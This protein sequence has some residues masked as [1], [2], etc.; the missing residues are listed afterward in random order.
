MTPD[1]Q[2]RGM[3][4][5]TANPEETSVEI[6]GILDTV[7][8]PIVVVG[9][10]CTIARFNLA[11]AELLSLQ[12]L[13]VRRPVFDVLPGFRNLGSL[14]GQAIAD[15]TPHQFQTRW[16]ARYFLVRIAP[17]SIGGAQILGA[18]LTFTN[19]TAFRAS[20]DQAIYER[21]YAKAILNTISE[22][23]VVLDGELRIQTGNRAFYTMFRVSREES[24]RVPLYELGNDWKASGLWESLKR[25]L[26]ENTGFQPVEVER[27]FAVIG[28]RT[29][30]IDARR[31]SL[32][33][34]EMLLLALHDITE[35]KNARQEIVKSEQ[36]LRNL[37]ESI[38]QLVWT[39]V[40]NGNYD[41]LS[42]QWVTYTGIPEAEQLGLRWL[43]LV[44]PEDRQRT[45]GAWMA[46]IEDRVPYDIEHRLKRFD[47][48]HRCFR[49]RGTPVRNSEGAI[50]K[51]FGTCTD[52]EDQK[53]AE[54][55]MLEQQ[56]RE[57]L[58]LLAG[59]IA[60]DFNNLLTGVLGNASL[61]DD[62]LEKTHPFRPLVQGIV[63]A[64]ERA[65]H[66]TR[67]MLAYAGKGR[68]FVERVDVNAL[69]R[70]TGSLVEASFPKSV[71]L[72]LDTVNQA[73]A[74]EADSG[75]IQQVIMNLA[76]NGAEAV[77]EEQTGTVRIR[78]A[79]VELDRFYL[80]EHSFV[81]E[82]PREGS[83]VCIEVE[84]TGAGIEPDNLT[85]IF[86]PF[87]T[88]KFTGR[89][90]GLAAVLGIVRSARGGIELSSEIGR[91]TRFRVFFP[92]LE[93]GLPIQ[94]VVPDEPMTTTPNQPVVLVIDDE[95]IVRQ[96]TGA[97]LRK[98]GYA[99]LLAEGGAEG[100]E[101]FSAAQAEI[102]LVILDMSM[103]VMSGKETLSRLRTI[104]NEVP[105]LIFS[106]YNEQHV[107]RHFEGMKISG[108][109]QKPFT[110]HQI[111]SA[112]HALLP[113]T[114]Q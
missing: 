14:C 111:A 19:V 76:M 88:T 107:Q 114:R 61:I 71:R 12:S 42:A 49:T 2:T 48:V 102:A 108:F 112:V 44:H 90:L 10:D 17:Y 101:I 1:G 60:H 91:G 30:L 99:V 82:A 110:G 28:L 100:V 74:I 84:D 57:S 27:E 79:I 73:L 32:E 31:L 51:W 62:C 11:A 41:Y 103:P 98:M 113:V 86:D 4:K 45:H 26:V 18:V 50:E 93:A 56:K 105:V 64:G 81:S 94:A 46:A 89:G 21:E 55:N 87:F 20:I 7:G 5:D 66:L 13:D 95:D 69:V 92:A 83:Y 96:T 109:V 67:Q 58:G 106:G 70:S 24:Q 97:M 59:G 63:E 43:N 29:I 23:L 22:P 80:E 85:R 53:V 39:S 15:G 47:G 78:T 75:Q 35:R 65:A 104:N 37:A 38:P 33:G 8:L 34:A 77:G 16:G 25:A 52:I 68:L 36:N 40:P 6:A 72:F 9:R 3:Q 54:R